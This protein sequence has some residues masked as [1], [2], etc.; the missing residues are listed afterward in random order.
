MILALLLGLG[1]AGRGVPP[2]EPSSGTTLTLLAFN[3]VYRVEGIPEAQQG[4]LARLRALRAQLEAAGDD[5]LVLGAG[6]FLSPSLLSNL[7]R[8]EQMVDVLNALD[9]APGT[10]DS[11]LILGF[12]NHEFDSGSCKGAAALTQR[13]AES[14]FTWLASNLRFGPCEGVPA[15]SG[16][17]LATT[18]LVEVRGVQ[19]GVLAVL[20]PLEAQVA[21]LAEQ[22]DPVAVVREQSAA[23]RAQGAE[24]VVAITHQPLAD[25]TALLETLG[26]AGPDLIVGG[27]EHQEL[28]AEVNGRWVVKASSDARSA[29]VWR[30]VMDRHGPSQIGWSLEALDATGPAP[31]PE[32]QARVDGWLTRHQTEFCEAN[33]LVP[34]CLDIT[35][36]HTQV[37]LEAEETAIRTRETTLGNWV[38]DEMRQAFIN[39]EAQAAL[40][41][42]GSLRLNQDL[43]AGTTLTRRHFEALLPFEMQLVLIEVDGATLQRVIERSVQD[44]TGQG[45]FL[46]ISGLRFAFDPSTGAVRGL[47]LQS[48]A[49]SAP[50]LPD[51]KIRVVVPEYLAQGN[52]GYSMLHPGLIVAEGEDLKSLLMARAQR[53]EPAGL[54]PQLEGRICNTAAGA[55]P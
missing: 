38:A 3:D 15:L 50:L 35:L 1:C 13:V 48:A 20:M 32:V 36:G 14:E 45:H 23:L 10:F 7:Y 30:V 11:R 2:H 4:G 51:Q 28:S 8:G 41:N 47:A 40:V 22:L 29:A 33:G 24:L 49:A 31:D 19:V 54:N 46:Q 16:S 27:H 43:P 21:Y 25:D 18:R 6:D 53:A 39:D 37:L 44:W 52:D 26:E 9:G 12:G 55:C 17:N 34:G 42:S 5:V